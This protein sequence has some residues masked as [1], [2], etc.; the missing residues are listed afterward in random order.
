M[1]R[2][3]D[4][5]LASHAS[6]LHSA[7][8]GARVHVTDDV[9]VADSGLHDDT[10][11]VVCR[12]R[13]GIPEASTRIEE[14]SDL[15][16]GTGRPFSWWVGPASTPEDLRALLTMH[17]WAE[18]D[19]ELA[20]AAR[21]SGVPAQAPR[22]GLRV[23]RVVDARTLRDYAGLLAANWTPA[24]ATVPVYFDAVAESILGGRCASV[25]V[26]GYV[27]GRPVSGAEVHLGDGVA[28]LYGVVTLEA[29]RGNGYAG[30]VTRAA[31]QVARRSG[32]SAAVLQAT[33][34]GAG[35]YS[36]LGFTP[37]GRYTEFALPFDRPGAVHTG[38]TRSP[39][40][41]L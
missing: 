5:N 41:A 14:T 38:G 2:A 11:N 34:R 21:L 29:F 23:E 17:G 20:M 15:V 28:G 27:D 9:L 37:V 1:L 36:R 33:A 35:V 16:A 26:V 31:L 13:F 18:Q 32:A 25:F 10:F 24:S 8:V 22:G 19:S 39:R 4:S 3:M 40:S 7:M 6:H 30:A 12:A